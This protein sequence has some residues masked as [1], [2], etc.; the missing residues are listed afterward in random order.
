MS[1]KA[2]IISDEPIP[3][4]IV[5]GFLGGAGATLWGDLGVSLDADGENAAHRT[6]KVLFASVGP[7]SSL[8][9]RACELFYS[10]VGGIVDYGDVHARTNNHLRY[11]RMIEDALY[12]EWSVTRPLHFLGHSMG[13]PTVVKMQ[14]LMKTGFFGEHVHPDMVLS[15]TA[16]SSP[17][18]GTQLV[19]TL[20]ER[21]DAPPGVRPFSIG[22]VLAK[23]VHL[24]S[25]LSPVLPKILDLH[26]ESRALS[27]RDASLCSLWQ[28]LFK[29]DWAE[30]KDATPYDVT[31]HAAQERE[32]LHEGLPNEKTFY[33]SYC[34][35]LAHTKQGE[36]GPRRASA[37]AIFSPL[38]LTSLAL[39]YF[40]FSK[41]RPTPEI[42]ASAADCQEHDAE[43]HPGGDSQGV[44]LKQLRENDGVVPLFS[45]F[46]P[47]KCSTA[48]C[49]HYFENKTWRQAKP[50]PG[51]W[52]VSILH[53]TSHLSI[54]PMWRGS[55][56]QWQ[57]WGDLGAW[58]YIVDCT[59]HLDSS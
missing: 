32:A 11:G 56:G 58:L 7:V 14:W 50:Y 5:E 4:V 28:Q 9:D 26:A 23:A 42:V 1:F 25:Y 53:D 2:L 49:R 15:L 41:L 10:L 52:D 17:F 29:S 33:R 22:S 30:G 16:I 55:Q 44:A 40:D 6:R 48:L 59:S 45:Q 46:H 54:A 37:A 35:F 3:L 18:R 19:Y 21:A 34:A 31:F 38:Y 39:V 36:A 20:G 47:F 12:P 24:V 43:F 27:F 51:V 13:G 8:H 57:F